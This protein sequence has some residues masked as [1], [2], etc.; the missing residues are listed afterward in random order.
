MALQ[1]EDAA[2]VLGV[3]YPECDIMF[4]MD[5]SSGHGKA[6]KGAIEVGKLNKLWGGNTYAVSQ[7]RDTIVR[8]V[9]VYNYNDDN[10]PQLQVNDVQKLTFQEIDKGPFY[11]KEPQRTETKYPVPS[12]NKKYIYNT[13]E[14][15]ELLK[16][17]I[18]IVPKQRY[19]K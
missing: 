8:E 17:K 1:M 11:V 9:G 16:Q 15:L 6:A 4:L 5:Q 19:L 13:S 2:D 10:N 7:I 14:L 18:N 12:T 3:V